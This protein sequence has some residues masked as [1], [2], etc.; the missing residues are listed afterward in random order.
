[1]ALG[2]R[3]YVVTG[4]DAY[5]T[6]LG[7][8]SVSHALLSGRAG[9]LQLHTRSDEG[10][11]HDDAWSRR[12]ARLAVPYDLTL[13][14]GQ[15]SSLVEQQM[16]RSQNQAVVELGGG[17]NGTGSGD[18]VVS[19]PRAKDSNE[20]PD[21]AD[22]LEQQQQQQQRHGPWGNTAGEVE[23]EEGGSPLSPTPTPTPTPTPI[24]P[25]L[26]TWESLVLW[27]TLIVLDCQQLDDAALWA[28]ERALSPCV[29]SHH[30]HDH[31]D[32]QEGPSRPAGPSA[33]KSCNFVL[34]IRQPGAKEG[35]AAGERP[36]PGTLGGD[37]AR[38]G[39]KL[40]SLGVGSV[41]VR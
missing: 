30:D 17:R 2:P 36:E 18:G 32:D 5:L 31:Q 23:P 6:S 38:L 1:M 3:F 21:G 24:L 7:R 4:P 33:H 11:H 20:E 16:L 39:W 25:P 22:G 35:C 12:R 10:D 15:F 41:V 9:A 19:E 13:G 37:L 14:T 29:E 34:E 27:A 8:G 26:S 28:L 40:A